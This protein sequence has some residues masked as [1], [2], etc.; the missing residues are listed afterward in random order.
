[1]R[2]LGIVVAATSLCLGG[3]SGERSDVDAA[4]GAGL[5]GHAHVGGGVVATVDGV[6]VTLDDVRRVRAETGLAPRAALDRLVEELLL[7]S[8]AQR[9]GLSRAP[10]VRR[11]TRQ[12]LA[13]A[14]LAREV[15]ARVTPESISAQDLDAAYE[16][17]RRRFDV[18]A[19]RASVH[20]L[21]RMGRPSPDDLEAAG[22]RFAEQALAD[23][24]TDTSPDAWLARHSAITGRRFEVRAERVPPLGPGDAADPGYIAALEGNDAPGA[25]P[26][27]VRTSFGWHAIVV[28]EVIPAHAVPRDEALSTLRTELVTRRR[29]ER[30]DQLLSELSSQTRVVRDEA[31]IRATFAADLDGLTSGPVPRP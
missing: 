15:E 12:A 11:A 30:L 10:R 6:A 18:P 16:T 31:T 5:A 24:S 29:A 2:S 3:C 8:E 17:E 20:V 25:V 19:R 14:L 9:R 21:A 4:L 13:Q 28:T 22:R 1:M 27:A 23:F 26:H 7:A